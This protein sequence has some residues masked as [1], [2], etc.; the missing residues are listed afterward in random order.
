M[1]TGTQYVGSSN[2]LSSRLSDYYTPSVLQRMAAGNSYIAAAILKYGQT[3]FTLEVLELGPTLDLD[4]SLSSSHP[5]LRPDYILLEQFMLDTYILGYNR[6]R[7][8]T[9]G[10]TPYNAPDHSG[11]N[12]PQHGLTGSSSAA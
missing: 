3:A 4:F 2:N 9:T 11:T 8:A 6:R 5:S 12:N 1:A 7:I 10:S